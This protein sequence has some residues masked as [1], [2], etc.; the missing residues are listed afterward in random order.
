[1]CSALDALRSWAETLFASTNLFT[2]STESGAL[3]S[4]NCSQIYFQSGSKAVN[5][6]DVKIFENTAIF[7][8]WFHF[9]LWCKE[10]DEKKMRHTVFVDMKVIWREEIIC[11]HDMNAFKTSKS[12]TNDDDN[13]NHGKMSVRSERKLHKNAH[14]RCNYYVAVAPEFCKQNDAYRFIKDDEKEKKNVVILVRNASLQ[15]E[16]DWNFSS[17]KYYLLSKRLLMAVFALCINKSLN[18]NKIPK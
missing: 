2:L 7:N 14:Q 8:K 13:H 10:N 17:S 18:H 5:E 4:R 9:K 11:W 6:F 15:T 1:M 3:C 12:M 16:N